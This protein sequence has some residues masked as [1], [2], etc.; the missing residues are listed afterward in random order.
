MIKFGT[1]GFRGVIGED[2][3]KRNVTLIAQ[4]LSD[5]YNQNGWDTPIV[6]GYD[7]RFMSDY[8]A[9]WM[10]EVFCA[11]NLKVIINDVS[12][13]TPVVMGA[14]KQMG[15][16]LGVMITASHNPYIF[17]GVKIFLKDGMDADAIFTGKLE[18]VVNSVTQVKSITLAKAKKQNLLTVKS[19]LKDYLKNIVDMIDPK[20]KSNNAKIL[21]D[22]MF[23]VGAVGLKP[24]SKLYNLKQF[25]IINEEHDAFFNF[26]PPNP[27]EG[28][29]AHLK[30]R[31][32]SEGYDYAIATDSDGDRLGVLDE[33]GNSVSS[34]DI[35]AML[36]YYLVNYRGQ[37]GDVVK[38]IATS[39]ILDK[40]AQKM[41]YKCHE[42]DVG[43][44]NISSKLKE[45]DALLGGESSG[46]LTVRNYIFG[47]DSVF[48]SSL[49]MEMQ[50]IMD[51]PVSEIVKEVRDFAEYN[52]VCKEESVTVSNL[53]VF[54][55][56]REISGDYLGASRI[57]LLNNNVKYYYKEDSWALIRA[58]GTEP[59]LRLFVE[60]KT[61]EECQKIINAMKNKILEIDA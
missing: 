12:V 17:N 59:L 56:I 11:N 27:T 9:E 43:F 51:K 10:A 7:R 19:C 20:I 39:V 37:K 30:D 18:K 25:D 35:L 60:A 33:K 26:V 53:S 36:Y 44:K 61:S 8:A 31:V 15:N 52:M 24:L 38:N 5:V 45:Q 46:G 14:T 42:V 1:G 28:A 32:V 55:K 49:F 40:L 57:S 16:H 41:G 3:T 50:I 4:G 6:I 2:F 34:N 54:N 47:K 23:G 13:P 29:M 22:N 48:S 58:S 21:F